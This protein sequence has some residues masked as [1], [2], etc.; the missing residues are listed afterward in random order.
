MITTDPSDPVQS[1]TLESLSHRVSFL[2]RLIVSHNP[3]TPPEPLLKSLQSVHST[4]HSL[5][6]QITPFID[7]YTEHRDYLQ[8]APPTAPFS[9][10]NVLEDLGGRKELV[11]ASQAELEGFADSLGELEGL[12][13]VLDS[14]A[15][16]GEFFYS[17]FHSPSH[18][19]IHVFAWLG[20]LDYAH[21]IVPLEAGLIDSN[22]QAEALNEKFLSIMNQFTVFVRS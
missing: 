8:K 20:L 16:E 5:S 7:L 9:A 12:K 4:L 11:L 18:F 21:E 3:S 6:P 14:K 13:E 15:V 1:Y 19:I 2:E 17:C 10:S 22:N